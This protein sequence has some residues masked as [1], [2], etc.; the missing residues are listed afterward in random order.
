MA[1]EARLANTP[2]ATLDPS[3]TQDVIYRRLIRILSQSN[4]DEIGILPFLAE[5]DDKETL[6]DLP[7]YP[8]VLQE[9][10]TK[11]GIPIFCWV[12]LLSEAYAILK[13]AIKVDTS[14]NGQDWWDISEKYNRVIE[15][16]SCLM[17]VCPDSFTAVNARK[18]LIEKGVLNAETELKFLDA[19][20]TIPRNCK[21]SGA[22]HHRKWL[23]CYMYPGLRETPLQPAIVEEQLTVCH[24]AAERYPKCYYAWTMRHWLVE[25]LGRHWW[26]ASFR[27]S[28]SEPDPVDLIPLEKEYERM[29]DHMGRNISDHSTQQHLQQCMLQLSGRWSVQICTDDSETG[30][31]P[32]SRSSCKALQWTREELSQRRRRRHERFSQSQDAGQKRDANRGVKIEATTPP[33]RASYPWVLRLWETELQ[34]TKDLI[35]SYPGHES[36]WYHL[37][38]VYY[39][40]QWVG[41]ETEMDTTESS[42]DWILGDTNSLACLSTEIEFVGHANQSDNTDQNAMKLQMLY[43]ER[44][45]DFIRLLD[46]SSTS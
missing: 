39:G 35:L 9:Q 16:T 46:W 37:R 29:K 11:L 40:M 7:L 8:F 19:I 24:Q 2:I 17:I 5:P 43:G 27:V 34:R 10:R 26:I 13:A 28:S 15:A 31:S 12:P 23:L 25:E 4:I 44:Y 32:P 38:F 6:K 36:L 18:R 42:V 21:S 30:P 1:S 41:S 14:S 45:L 22:W 20:L 3:L 33:I